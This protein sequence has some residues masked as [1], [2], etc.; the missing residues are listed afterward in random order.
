VAATTRKVWLGIGAASIVSMASEMASPPA[1]AQHAAGH[2]NGPVA[3]PASA[4]AAGQLAA[5]QGGEAYLSDGGPKDTRIRIYRDIALMRGHLLVGGEL[6]EQG[7]WDEALPHFLHPTEELYGAMERY[8]KL[9]KVTPFDR[10]LKA[11]AQAVKAKN[12]A[13]YQQASKVVDIRLTNALEAFKRF[14]TVQPF[15]SYTARTIVEVLKVAKAEYEAAIEDG[16]FAKPVEYQD[17]RGFVLHAGQLLETHANDLGKVDAS[18]VGELRRLLADLKAAWPTA[19]PPD[20]P[21]LDA[22]GV[23]ARIDAIVAVAERFF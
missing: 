17:S 9:H 5:P 16:R 3:A 20:K 6:I 19:V 13:A 14:M 18:S 12:K 4:H 10:Q 23:G 15:S 2:K 22:A 1:A 21:L 7:L 8:I 11:L